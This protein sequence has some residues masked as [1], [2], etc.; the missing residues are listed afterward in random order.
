M[1][2]YSLP[3]TKAEIAADMHGSEAKSSAPQWAAAGDHSRT[4]VLPKDEKEACSGSPDP[5][6][7][8]IPGAAATLG[9][10]AA[11]ACAG[12]FPSSGPL[13]CLIASLAAGLLFLPA[14]A[15]TLPVL[16]RWMMLLPSLA[17]G[18]SVAFTM[19]QQDKV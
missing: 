13:G 2:I 16:T 9:V 15:S 17:G 10:L 12:L 7:A 4:P 19:R 6:D 18:A 5:E 14:M 3:L 8:K 11:I 1:R